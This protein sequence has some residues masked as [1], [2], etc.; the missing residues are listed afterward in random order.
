MVTV[1]IDV[2]CLNCNF[3]IGDLVDWVF[4]ST[5]T[6]EPIQSQDRFWHGEIV[7]EW[8]NR[9]EQGHWFIVKW[10]ESNRPGPYGGPRTTDFHPRFQ[11]YIPHYLQER[12][13]EIRRCDLQSNL[14]PGINNLRDRPIQ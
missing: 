2:P 6:N 7:D 1:G 10:T 13:I 3:Q 9:R 8:N 4:L 11:P 14:H 12:C 5:R